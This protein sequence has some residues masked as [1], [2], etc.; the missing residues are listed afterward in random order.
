[1]KIACMALPCGIQKTAWITT[2]FMGANC[3]LNALIAMVAAG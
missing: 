2:T 3:V 1:M